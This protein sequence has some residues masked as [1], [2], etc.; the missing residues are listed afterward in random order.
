MIQKVILF[1]I[2][3]GET[4]LNGHFKCFLWGT[5]LLPNKI[6]FLPKGSI[7]LPYKIA[8]LPRGST[9]QPITTG[10]LP[11]GSDML[12]YK[13]IILPNKINVLVKGG[14]IKS[15][16]ISLLPKLAGIV[17]MGKILL[18]MVYMIVSDH[19]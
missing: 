5:A 12:P 8:L 14:I 9:L 6:A 19:A 10:I 3:N 13:I 17:L 11:K 15:Y 7:M 16:K 4:G 1:F 18:F 2:S